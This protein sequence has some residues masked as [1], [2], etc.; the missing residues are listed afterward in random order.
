MSRKQILSRRDFLRLSAL[1]S[2]GFILAACA[3]PQTAEPE[4]TGGETADSGTNSIA[5]TA[6][7]RAVSA[8]IDEAE[9]MVKDVVEF[10][11]ESDE[12]EGDFG[13][14]TFQLHE[15]RYNGS[16]VYF[17]RTDA[18][19][20]AFAEEVGLVYVPL[21]NNGKDLAHALYWFD[22]DRPP[23]FSSS[24]SSEAFASLCHLIQVSVSDDG[25]T[26]ESAADV[27]QAIADGNATMSDSNV[28][29]NYPFIKWDGGELSVD[30]ER[31]GALPNGQLLEP[32]DTD[33]MRVT[34]KL[35]QCFPGSR[36]ILTDTSSVGMAPMMSVPA[37]APTQALL[38]SGGTDEIWIFVN[39]IEGPGVMG[40]QPA[41]FDN[42]AGEP[43]WSPFWDH[44]ALKWVDE[45]NARILRSSDEIREALAAGE[46]EEFLGVPDTHP[47]GFVVNCPAPILAANTYGA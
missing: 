22:D 27:E 17:I 38:D 25:L 16:E 30:N 1:S 21:L 19:D 34:L 15:G 12:W 29:V 42:K 24:P 23:V 11:L 2:G 31:V 20:Q 14:V 35:H 46:L 32:I 5:A 26:L 9:V 18:S 41:I 44:R 7:A 8:A 47:N 6:T 4:T 39:G 10:K 43:A 36:Y 3:A 33:N 37:S 13:S 45:S 40:F 28:Y